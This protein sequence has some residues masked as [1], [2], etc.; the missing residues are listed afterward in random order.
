MVDFLRFLGGLFMWWMII[1]FAA[2]GVIG[3]VAF[4]MEMRQ[5]RKDE[6]E[7]RRLHAAAA[8]T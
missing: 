7:M 1:S 8:R 2:V 6:I 4:V 3:I 5:I